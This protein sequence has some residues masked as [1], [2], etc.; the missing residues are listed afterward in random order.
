MKKGIHGD[1]PNSNTHWKSNDNPVMK[2]QEQYSITRDKDWTIIR[3]KAVGR[4]KIHCNS[5]EALK[6]L[7]YYVEPMIAETR[8][9]IE[10]RVPEMGWY[11]NFS[12]CNI[13]TSEAFEEAL[14][15]A[16]CVERDEN[17]E[18]SLLLIVSVVSKDRPSHDLST[19]LMCG[20]RADAIDYLK[21]IEA[22]TDMIEVIKQLMNNV[23]KIINSVL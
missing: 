3:L 19:L 6:M 18:G 16:L 15:I 9:K 14:D 22:Q 10:E 5:P 17:I 13:D 21:S 7:A 4:E 1:N 2:M 20:K 8:N 23:K 12:A 11:M